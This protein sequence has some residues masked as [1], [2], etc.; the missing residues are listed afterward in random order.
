MNIKKNQYFLFLC[1]CF[2]AL[3][4]VWLGDVSF[5]GDE[6]MLLHKALDANEAGVLAKIGLKGSKGT[7]Y[8][9]LAT[10]IYQMLLKITHDMDLLILLKILLESALQFLGVM[11][12]RRHFPRWP[13][14]VFLLIF[15]SPYFFFY[16]RM[17]WDNPFNLSFSLLLFTGVM[18]F[19]R[20]PSFLLLFRT[21][22]LAALCLSIHLMSVS[23]LL[24]L[25]L[26]MILLQ[27]KYLL[28]KWYQVLFSMVA[29]LTVLA[30]Y[31]QFL[32]ENSGS[33]A[34]INA[35]G[36]VLKSLDGALLG[37]RLLTGLGL[38]YFY[39]WEFSFF[40]FLPSYLL[41]ALGVILF[42]CFFWAFYHLWIPVFRVHSFWNID[43]EVEGIALRSFLRIFFV[44]HL[45]FCIA[46]SLYNH[47]HYYNASWIPYWILTAYGLQCAHL[48]SSFWLKKLMM[49]FP[50]VYVVLSF[51]CL[52]NVLA[53]AHWGDG[54]RSQ[55][56]GPSLKHQRELAVLVLKSG[57]H[58]D[59]MS[60]NPQ[61]L[62][63]LLPGL[64]WL[65]RIESGT[66]QFDPSSFKKSELSY[67]YP[68]DKKKS[69]LKLVL[70]D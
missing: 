10:W 55:H 43:D 66:T 1:A 39:G 13:A 18:S 41:G 64:R 23:F 22:L 11:E 29:A 7:F 25:A 37:T 57:S 47:P 20:S 40:E 31:I 60:F 45:L 63:G 50:K 52:L 21:A 56:Y 35:L 42:A 3:R 15:M 48:T 34:D 46:T 49:Y 27:R 70:L 24:S 9:P 19:V 68:D 16:S 44:I 67:L 62:S 6:A 5:L 33:G 69:T 58:P 54:V 8:G 12:L 17:F 14:F 53:L 59:L 30:P 65:Y 26:W 38:N 61:S 28:A 32:I 2:I 36:S 51:L 4:F